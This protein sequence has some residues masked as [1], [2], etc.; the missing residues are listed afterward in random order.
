MDSPAAVS[1]PKRRT[2]APLRAKGPV[3]RVAKALGLSIRELAEKVEVNYETMRV[4]NTRGR[5][6]DDAILAK[7]DSLEAEH[8]KSSRKS[9]KK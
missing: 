1:I 5:V 2:G 8:L 6:P 4:W 7:F 3:G 9:G